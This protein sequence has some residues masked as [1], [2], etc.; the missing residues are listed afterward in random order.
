[1]SNDY[2]FAKKKQ[3]FHAVN[4]IAKQNPLRKDI[5]L[6]K[7][8]WKIIDDSS[9]DGEEVIIIEGKWKKNNG[10]P[11]EPCGTPCLRRTGSDLELLTHT[12]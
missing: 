12:I 3:Q 7:F 11:T 4:M 2:R 6:N 5:S 9:Y 1:M 8:K 10:L